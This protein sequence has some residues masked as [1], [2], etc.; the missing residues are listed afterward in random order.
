MQGQ[1]NWFTFIATRTA[2]P[3][4]YPIKRYIDETH[5]LHQTLEKGL[6]G[7][8]FLVGN[9]LTIADVACFSW[10]IYAPMLGE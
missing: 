2:E 7:K 10:A 1:A 8:Q 4:P 6:E 3:Q 9:K 5:R